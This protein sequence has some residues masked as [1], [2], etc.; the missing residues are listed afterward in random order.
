MKEEV[1]VPKPK[2]K[3]FFVRVFVCL[4]LGLIL[5]FVVTAWFVYQQLNK[6]WFDEGRI[7]YD[8]P[9]LFQVDSASTVRSVLSEINAQSEDGYPMFNRLAL[10]LLAP[11]V[12]VK[13]GEY[14]VSGSYSRQQLFDLFGS[15]KSKQHAV[16]LI[17]GT[18]LNE[19]LAA[20]SEQDLL[21]HSMATMEDLSAIDLLDLR[22]IEIMPIGLADEL[23]EMQVLEGWFFPDTYNFDRGV[24][25]L[26]VL[27]RSHKKMLEILLQEWETR[28]KDLPLSSAYEAL[29]LASI[30]ERESGHVDE[31]EKIAG[32]FIRR[33]QKG[34]RLQT[35]PT[36]IYG[37]GERY[38]GNLRR[39]D[40][41]HD[42]P[43]NTYTRDGLPPTPIALPGQASIR[44]ALHPEPGTALY[45]VAK[46]DGSHIFSDTLDQHNRAVRKYQILQRRADYQSAPK[47]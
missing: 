40:L 44:A 39:Q 18:T 3:A 5:T 9:V 38:T 32:V 1:F 29:I 37:M 10:K 20:L 28:A 47:K 41:K 11:D 31:R 8:E 4:F 22:A 23:G 46:G 17:E 42:T 15:G 33:L 16:T 25:I 12:I 26:N 13:R 2:P 14:E 34:M 21:K 19:T 7:Y 36:V 43:Y 24:G 6:Y 35:D 27:K 45:F 30:I